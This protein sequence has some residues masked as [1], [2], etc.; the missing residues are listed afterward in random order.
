MWIGTIPQILIGIALGEAIGQLI[1]FRFRCTWI[2]N[3]VI[4][5][6]G[7]FV[8][9]LMTAVRET[10]TSF[11]LPHAG[12]S[13]IAVSY[14]GWLFFR[15]YARKKRSIESHD[16]PFL[17]TLKKRESKPNT[18]S[19]PNSK[20][21]APTSTVKQSP[22]SPI[23]EEDIDQNSENGLD[24][25]DLEFYEQV[26]KELEHDQTDKGIWAKAFIGCD[27]DYERT[28]A[29]YIRMRVSELK[30]EQQARIDQHE[31]EREREREQ[32]KHK[33]FLE[34]LEKTKRKNAEIFKNAEQQR[35]QEQQE[36]QRVA[37][38][39]RRRA[40]NAFITG[41]ALTLLICLV[42]AGLLL[43]SS[44]AFA[45][46]DTLPPPN[47]WCQA[48]KANPSATIYPKWRLIGYEGY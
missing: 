20:G 7:L 29:S 17:A 18:K 33:N 23:E 25:S 36:K 16:D 46:L 32:E 3:I 2:T 15:M 47:Q 48:G 28:K 12:V 10:A 4:I 24:D 1:L 44:R 26:R 30:A 9:I 38:T 19:T 40:D 21:N 5:I 27:G 31:R 42:V 39:A 8:I 13:G 34:T 22:P 41:W 43:Y 35:K 6:S 45:S 37:E 14:M 11:T